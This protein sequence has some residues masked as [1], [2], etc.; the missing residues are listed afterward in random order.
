MAAVQD[1]SGESETIFSFFR[2]WHCDAVDVGAKDT[3]KTCSENHVS[4]GPCTEK[5]AAA[6]CTDCREPL[7]ELPISDAVKGHLQRVSRRPKRKRAEP[8]AAPPAQQQQYTP[9]EHEQVFAFLR[10][11]HCGAIDVDTTESPTAC[12]SLHFACVDC[13]NKWESADSCVTCGTPMA[14]FPINA[15]VT[16]L[17]QGTL[18]AP[19][20][21]KLSAPSDSTADNLPQQQEDANEVWTRCPWHGCDFG[22]DGG[23]SP[24]VIRE[25]Y[26]LS[27]PLS[28]A[29][30]IHEACRMVFNRRDAAGKLILHPGFT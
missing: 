10:C 16:G 22:I 7:Q 29:E 9:A 14:L 24:E 23:L 19:K 20:R 3:F 25:H 17:L 5:A 28:P 18:R 13:R 15:D 8:T 30:C 6:R 26:Q 4:C 12:A 21:R 2:C 27:C 1:S 11:W